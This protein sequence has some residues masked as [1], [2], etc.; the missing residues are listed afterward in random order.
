MKSLPIFIS[1]A[2]G[3]SAFGAVS[4]SGDWT[5]ASTWSDSTVPGL[6]SDTPLPT[7]SF[8]STG[9]ELNV[10]ENAWVNVINVATTEKATINIAAGKTLTFLGNASDSDPKEIFYGTKDF[11]EVVFNGEGTISIENPSERNLGNGIWTFN[12]AVNQGSKT[13]FLANE[14]VLNINGGW[15]SSGQISASNTTININ[16]KLTNT[17]SLNIW[18]VGSKL[19]IAEGIEVLCG[20]YGMVSGT[21]KGNIVATSMNGSDQYSISFGRKDGTRGTIL[22]DTTATMESK[23]TSGPAMV[24]NVNMTINSA[25]GSIKTARC[26]GTVPKSP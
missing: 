1:F 8:D 6:S 15:T 13:L 12:A 17:S 3:A 23:H 20:S 16:S 4:Q 25:A 14:G 2:L 11:S 26:I 7:L 19:N 22:F 24:R 9:L 5:S 21:I 10:N 18:G